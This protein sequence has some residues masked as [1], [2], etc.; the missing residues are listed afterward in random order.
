MRGVVIVGDGVNDAP[1]LVAADVGVAM[2]GIGSGAAIEAAIIKLMKDRL[3]EIPYL[4]DL[5]RKT[6]LSVKQNISLSIAVE[7]TLN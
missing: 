1:S 4:L 2:G 6:M 7:L 5:S 3:S